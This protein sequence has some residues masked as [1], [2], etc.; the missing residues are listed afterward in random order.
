MSVS[1]RL[2]LAWSSAALACWTAP[3]AASTGRRRRVG[4]RARGVVVGLR[5]ELAPEQVLRPRE[6]ALGVGRLRL[7]LREVARGRHVVRP[8]L[9]DLGLEE[10]GVDLGQPLALLH[11][12]VEVG[13]DL[14]DA[15][16]HLAADLHGDQGRERAARGHLRDDRPAIDGRGIVADRRRL[17]L[18]TA[19]VDDHQA[20]DQRRG[21]D[22]P[23]PP[24][25]RAAHGFLQ[26][27]T[28]RAARPVPPAR[29]SRRTR[30]IHCQHWTWRQVAAAGRPLV[31]LLRRQDRHNVGR[32]A[33]ATPQELGEGRVTQRSGAGGQGSGGRSGQGSGG[34]DGQGSG[35]SGQRSGTR[36]QGSGVSSGPRRTSRPWPCIYFMAELFSI[37]K[38]VDV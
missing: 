27:P 14:L 36:G 11:G 3:L 2:I 28:T 8:R 26:T 23:R 18:G 1:A 13:V 34:Q 17:A 10:A 16:R 24:P 25:T 22:P 29:V 7:R 12:R 38:F 19:V 33:P 6:L 20:E 4:V 32:F 37:G 31:A 5:D 21:P 35:S 9:L 15:A 30:A